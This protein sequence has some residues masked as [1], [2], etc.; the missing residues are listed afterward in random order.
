[1]IDV[2]LATLVKAHAGVAARVTPGTETVLLTRDLPRVIYTLIGVTRRYS[3]GGNTGLAQ[4]RYQLDVFADKATEAR[5]VAD[6]IRVG[7]DGHKG[8]TDG[9]RIDRVYFDA[10]NFAK[11]EK[12]EGA[13][14]T[15]ARYSQ[16]V[17]IEYR[18]A[19]AAPA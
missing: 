6:A 19:T 8:T 5:A 12:I 3:D 18:E 17:I 4:A 11:G 15:V 7:L 1:M 2:A 9:T 14:R 10:E 13:N 16:D